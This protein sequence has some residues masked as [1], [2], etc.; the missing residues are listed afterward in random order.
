MEK[1]K[2]SP[3]EKTLNGKICPFQELGPGL[4]GALLGSP[5]SGAEVKREG[6]CK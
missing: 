1:K 5:M 2:D 4:T 3:G 6:A